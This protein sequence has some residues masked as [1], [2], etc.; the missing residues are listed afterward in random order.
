MLPSST[1]EASHR[2]PVAIR[3]PLVVGAA[4]SV[5]VGAP[6]T[7]LS[8]QPDSLTRHDSLA[9]RKGAAVVLVPMHVRASIVPTA[10]PEVSSGVPA[11]VSS[12]TGK[13][14]DAWEPR[15][16]P[17]LLG[18]LAGVS[19][20][21]DLGS[22]GKLNLST[23]GFT[24]GPTVGL[25]SGVSVFVDGI[26]QNEPDAQEVNFD[27]LPLE[28]VARVEL[29]SG[30]ASLLGA[31]SL[32]G[33][34]NLITNRG[35]GPASAELELSAA[36]FGG[37]GG[38][39][40]T[41]GSTSGGIDYYVSGGA[42]RERGWRTGTGARTYNGFVNLGWTGGHRAVTLQAYGVR[43]RAETA[44]SLPESL[45]DA[46]PRTNFTP[47]DFED[48]NAAQL[49]LSAYA[50]VAVGRASG[51]LYLRRSHAERFN[52]NQVPDPNVRS[53]T[54]NLSVGATA[55]WRWVSGGGLALRVGV[56]GAANRVRIRIFG[57]PN[58]PA[59]AAPGI[60]T[61]GDVGHLGLTTDVRSPSWDLAGYALA[62]YR[63]GHVT[64]SGGGRYDY[65]R[66]PYRNEV[67]GRDDT[68]SSY[69]RFSP[70]FGVSV[71]VR[72]GASVY[73]SVG[74]SFRAPA[75]LEL[76]C[77]DPEAAC[78]LPF[79]LGDDP[80]LLP[81]RAT[82]F[83]IGTRWLLGSLFLTASAYRTEVR[84]EIF[85]VA[86]DVARLSG[87]FTNLPR[88]R[89]QGIEI[90]VQGSSAGDRITWY[91]NYAYTGAT[92]QSA[93]V[94]FSPRSDTSVADSPLAG[95]NAVA[96][97]R[98]LPLVPDHQVKGGAA[99]KLGSDLSFG[100]EARYVG[101]QW[102]RGDEANETRPLAPYT[103][104]NAR[105]GL[106]IG[107]WEATIVATNLLDSHAAV[108]GTFNRNRRS[109]ELERF[110]T[111]LTARSIKLTLRRTLGA[112][113]TRDER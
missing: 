40:R 23:R 50:P 44:G 29:L 51:T 28:H 59:A 57:E 4:A 31:N 54:A 63:V 52:V 83:E 2:L 101:R 107:A 78:P 5:L 38:E 24:V 74:G 20:Y 3:I 12:M 105:V 6:S 96:V 26:R 88:T 11:R 64:F 45:F 81:V 48:L 92:L 47:G 99:L 104:A 90:G 37:Y 95:P 73:G 70:R 85:F 13:E 67:D 76:G 65:V 87:Y 33:A 80:P 46:A 39:G 36:S 8:Q 27:L 62:D 17:D 18:T 53:L 32:G 14:I 56:D 86:S 61:N 98:H 79:A 19:F 69:R 34:I 82:T 100:L 60:P 42:E 97:G 106:A 71:D 72:P 111:P 21:D 15:L 58:S 77:A 89:R 84:D 94:L 93:V 41:L 25:P 102:L 113:S 91:G 30:S 110:L 49:A 68:T 10:A 66:V 16:L 108:F 103:L 22:P 7:G 112:G 109:D 1:R 9:P 35:Q 75:I 55:D 43:S